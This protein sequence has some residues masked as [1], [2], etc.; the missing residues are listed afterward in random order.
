M[1]RSSS[2]KPMDLKNKDLV[3]IESLS[4]EE[5]NL[6]LDTA[7]TMKEVSVRDVKKVPTL[8]GKTVVI[9]FLEASTRTRA[10]F[11]IAAKRLSADTLGFTG[12]GSS[13]SKGETLMDMARNIQA[14]NPDLLVIRH[15]ASGAPAMLARILKIPVI[16]AGD[17][18]HEHPTQ[19]LLDMLTIK[20]KKGR[21][22]GLKVV[23][24]GD[25]THSRVARSDL[26]ALR[27]L[28]CEIRLCGPLTMIPPYIQELGAKVF[29]NFDEAVE[30]VDVIMM[31]R[32]Q[33]ERQDAGLFPTVREYSRLYGITVERIA[34]AK[35]DVII[36]HPG[37]I[38]RG[39]EISP[40]VADG[41]YSVILDQVA[42]GVAVRMAVLYLLASRGDGSSHVSGGRVS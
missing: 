14:M 41:P 10:S 6:I 29:S 40:E 34:K 9:L 1:T 16:N 33:L 24:V 31:L 23:I 3:D 2:G 38:N 37:P 21:L 11:E 13:L 20:E 19:G 32:I 30:G 8:R 5:L 4:V 39:I 7:E 18:T 36:M 15:Q 25:I 42:N 22:K 27:K 17:G 12:T 28:G 35:K 26:H